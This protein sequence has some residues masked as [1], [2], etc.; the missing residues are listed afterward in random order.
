MCTKKI[1]RQFCLAAGLLIMLL[2]T[3][4]AMAQQRKEY[5]YYTVDSGTAGAASTPTMLFDDDMLTKWCVLKDFV[6]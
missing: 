5:K 6:L 3:T 2:A 1:S 4:G